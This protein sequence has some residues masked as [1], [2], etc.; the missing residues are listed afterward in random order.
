M[1]LIYYEISHPKYENQCGVSKRHCPLSVNGQHD[2]CLLRP[3]AHEAGALDGSSQSTLTAYVQM[4][5]RHCAFSPGKERIPCHLATIRFI[6]F[7]LSGAVS[8]KV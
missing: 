2:D 8:L 6:C 7:S 4:W 5:C 3:A 1:D